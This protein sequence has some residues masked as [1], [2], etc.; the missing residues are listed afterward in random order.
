MENESRVEE[1]SPERV[2][3]GR[4]AVT[5]LRTALEELPQRTRAIFLLHR[6]EG[7]KY[8]EIAR[9]LGIS[10]SSV[11]KHMM[12]AIKHVRALR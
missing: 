6:F 9:R 2:L 12:A 1:I 7:L 8:K 4:Q 3:Q 5:A 10:S 11:E